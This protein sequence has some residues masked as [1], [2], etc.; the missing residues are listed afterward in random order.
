MIKEEKTDMNIELIQNKFNLYKNFIENYLSNNFLTIDVKNQNRTN[1]SI[2]F[3]NI[4]TDINTIKLMLSDTNI[5]LNLEKCRLLEKLKEYLQ[6]PTICMVREFFWNKFKL[7]G[8]K[9]DLISNDYYQNLKEIPKEYKK[10]KK[11]SFIENIFKN[12]ELYLKKNI[13]YQ[14]LENSIDFKQLENYFKEFFDKKLNEKEIIETIID[15]KNILNLDE[16]LEIK[17]EDLYKYSIEIFKLMLQDIQHYQ[18]FNYV[19][20]L[21]NVEWQ[22]LN[23]LIEIYND[24]KEN[25]YQIPKEIENKLNKGKPKL[26]DIDLILINWVFSIYKLQK[27]QNNNIN[28]VDIN[29]KSDILGTNDENITIAFQTKNINYAQELMI[30]SLAKKD[31]CIQQKDINNFIENIEKIKIKKEIIENKIKN[32]E[33]INNYKVEQEIKLIYEENIKNKK[34]TENINTNENFNK[35]EKLIEFISDFKNIQNLL[36][37]IEENKDI[38]VLE[39]KNINEINQYQKNKIDNI[40]KFIN[41]C[42]EKFQLKFHYHKFVSFNNYSIYPFIDNKND[43]IFELVKNLYLSSEIIK[44]QNNSILENL[45]NSIYKIDKDKFYFKIKENY[46][47]YLKN[48]LPQKLSSIFKIESKKDKILEISIKRKY[49]SP[50]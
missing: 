30:L 9:N 42:K 17:K 25:F 27:Y 49:P 7:G 15:F 2:I 1:K 10:D 16:N 20:I 13:N 48:T 38:D 11:I 6:I 19:D 26:A 40:I 29:K 8:F 36:K 34:I 31:Y 24:K 21:K 35:I 32:K 39:E 47:N 23:K 12:I 41:L 44:S 43:T 5:L 37:N 33:K 50:K 18:D 28:N 22:D 45:S 46:F 14:Q 4:N 3:L